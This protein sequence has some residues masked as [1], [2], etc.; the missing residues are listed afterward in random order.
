MVGLYAN[1][2]TT[3]RRALLATLACTSSRSSASFIGL[4][5]SSRGSLVRLTLPLWGQWR[6]VTV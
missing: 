5:S 4:A 2:L 1:C 6:S 3:S